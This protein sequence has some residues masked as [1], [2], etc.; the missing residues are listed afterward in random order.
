[1]D[2]GGT[3]SPLDWLCCA[4]GTHYCVLH[5]SWWTVVVLCGPWWIFVTSGLTLLCRQDTASWPWWTRTKDQQDH[6]VPAGPWQFFATSKLA[7]LCRRDTVLS[8]WWALIDKTEL[9]SLVLVHH[10]QISLNVLTG[11]IMVSLSSLV[12]LGGPSSPPDCPH[13]ADSTFL[14]SSVLKG[15]TWSSEH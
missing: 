6:P 1:M 12:Y 7:S 2:L 9:W 3:P 5:R 10:L 8:P 11:H 15:K 4:D 13:C 14:C